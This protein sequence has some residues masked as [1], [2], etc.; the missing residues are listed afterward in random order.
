MPS[1][2]FEHAPVRLVDACSVTEAAAVV[3]SR[4]DIAVVVLSLSSASGEAGLAFARHVRI[5]IGN[6]LVRILLYVGG[7]AQMPDWGDI[8]RYD[9][10]EC[11]PMSDVS[12]LDMHSAVMKALR[13]YCKVM[14]LGGEP[15][16]G[17]E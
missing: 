9:I 12:T 11:K 15:V 1:L 16:R 2:V 13:E 5:T 6:R 8:V 3:E 4:Q 7:P 14:A 10:D 17:P